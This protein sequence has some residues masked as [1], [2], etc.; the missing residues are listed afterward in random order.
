M[1]ERQ[2]EGIAKAK[3]EGKYKGRSPTAKAKA[4]EVLAMHAEGV[5]VRM[6]ARGTEITEQLVARRNPQLGVLNARRIAD[7]SDGNARLAFA[8]ADALPGNVSLAGL[9]DDELFERLFEQRH[10]FDKNLRK[11]A[12]VLSL[13]YSFS[14]G[15]DEEGVSELAVLG[16]LCEVS[17]RR[18]ARASNTLL[19]RQIAQQRGRWRAVLPHAIANRLAADALKQIPVDEVLRAFEGNAGARMLRS[20]SRRIEFLHASA[21]AGHHRPAAPLAGNSCRLPADLAPAHGRSCSPGDAKAGRS[22]ADCCPY[23]ARLISPHGPRC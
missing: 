23:Y 18:M 13:V 21:R 9:S 19:E 4:K 10:E 16:D 22:T 8:L 11:Q 17:A 5:G 2:R 20:F 12:E 14:T 1:L 6:T 3:A 7:F 15:E